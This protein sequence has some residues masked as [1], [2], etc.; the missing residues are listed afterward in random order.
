[1]ADL[2]RFL[3]NIATGSVV[4]TGQLPAD[5]LNVDVMAG[6]IEIESVDVASERMPLEVYAHVEAG[7]VVALA[8]IKYTAFTDTGE[9]TV[10][11][12]SIQATAVPSSPFSSS[13]SSVSSFWPEPEMKIRATTEEGSVRAM[14]EFTTKFHILDLVASGTD[15]AFVQLSA[16]CTGC[17]HVE[18]LS[19]GSMASLKENSGSVSRIEYQKQTA[20]IKEGTKIGLEGYLVIGE[21]NVLSSLGNAS[22]EFLH[23]W[24]RRRP[25]PLSG[26]S[27]ASFLP[28]ELNIRAATDDGPVHAVIQHESETTHLNLEVFGTDEVSVWSLD[29]FSGWFHVAAESVSVASVQDA[30]SKSRVE[31]QTLTA[32]IKAGEN[33]ASVGESKEGSVNVES[34]PGYA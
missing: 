15:S 29:T 5:L 22:L 23:C 27:S 3:F 16:V 8:K 32:Q 20:Q 9:A 1:M 7:D 21:V 18:A 14:V 31:Y 24:R 13:W 25:S 12:G 34:R 28:A 11:K 19:E 17:F 2:A 33:F 6:R 10:V 26:F 4:G 30:G